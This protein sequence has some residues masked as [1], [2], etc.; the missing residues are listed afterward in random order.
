MIWIDRPVQATEGDYGE[1]EAHFLPFWSE[2]DMASGSG[3]G[4][5]WATWMTSSS[6]STI[7][8]KKADNNICSNCGLVA[9]SCLIL[10]DPI[11]CS[12]PS[13]SVQGIF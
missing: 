3:T 9:Q 1:G 11:D 12:L 7:T 6:L 13:S 5:P 10:Y 2:L 8:G 4:F